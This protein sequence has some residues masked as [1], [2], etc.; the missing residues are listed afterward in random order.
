MRL[1]VFGIGYVGTVVAAC[2]AR[3][4]HSVCAVDINQDKVD[5]LARGRSPVIEPGLQALVE[6]GR[7][8]GCPLLDD[9]GSRQY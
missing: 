1:S 7:R 8:S 5:A 3:D 2:L 6:H 4:G 9:A